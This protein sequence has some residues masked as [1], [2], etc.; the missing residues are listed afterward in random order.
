MNEGIT[1]PFKVLPVITEVGRTKLEANVSVRGTFSN[2]L[3]ASG[4]GRGEGNGAEQG[5]R[6]VSL[7]GACA[8]F[9]RTGLALLFLA[10]LAHWW[11]TCL[12]SGALGVMAS[13]LP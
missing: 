9:V 2:K 11:D 4:G 13:T 6:G 5:G 3:Q 12:A 10:S 1:L 7:P 8:A